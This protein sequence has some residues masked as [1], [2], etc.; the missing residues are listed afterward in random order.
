MKFDIT[1]VMGGTVGRKHS[2]KYLNSDDVREDDCGP[3][4]AQRQNFIRCERSGICRSLMFFSF[5]I[6]CQI[7]SI[8][9]L[10]HD[11]SR[12]TTYGRNGVVAFHISGLYER[13]NVL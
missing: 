4:N 12:H 3:K 9:Y 6:L 8:L 5:S 7:V 1:W 11:F 13:E 2:R 10:H